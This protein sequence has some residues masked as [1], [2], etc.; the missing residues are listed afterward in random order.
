MAQETLSGEVVS[1]AG[2]D[3]GFQGN[4]TLI[5]SAEDTSRACAASISHGQQ[6]ISLQRGQ[7]FPIKF[8]LPFDKSSAEKVP[9][10]LTV[11]ARIED[12]N[13]KL[14][15]INDT[16]TKLVDNVQIEVIKV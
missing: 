1:S 14:L 8:Y 12:K 5:V 4:E 2:P 11:N 3:G 15:Y 13:G 7:K 16:R 6:S 9:G 10:G